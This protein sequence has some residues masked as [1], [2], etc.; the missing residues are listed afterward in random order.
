MFKNGV[1]IIQIRILSNKKYIMQKDD[2]LSSDKQVGFPG[3]L[4]Y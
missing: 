3:A 4:G 2:P 1:S